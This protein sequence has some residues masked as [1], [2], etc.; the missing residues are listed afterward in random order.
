LKAVKEAR[1]EQERLRKRVI[2]EDSFSAATKVGGCDV[3]CR[4]FSYTI[5]AGFVTLID[6]KI[7]A[8]SSATSTTTVPY[9]PGYL[10][11]REVPALLEAYQCL[12]QKPDVLCVDGHGVCHP[13][14]LGVASHLGVV[15]DIPTIGVGKS[16]LIGKPARELGTIAGDQTDL[17]WEG[18][19][20]GIVLRTKNRCR[21]I[22]V[23]AGHKITLQT[24][25]K[26]VLELLAGYRL[27]EPT[28]LAHNI[29]NQERIAHG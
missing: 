28:R 3:S 22:I 10:A 27:P 29:A 4:R 19:Q 23:S 25:V 20:V 6:R 5:H 15:L 17:V 11:F 21:P 14:G 26:L 1:E 2:L 8:S 16:I 18:K 12:S 13:R 24:A 7:V 9:I